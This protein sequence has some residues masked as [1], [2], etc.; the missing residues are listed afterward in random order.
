MRPHTSTYTLCSIREIKLDPD[1]VG[2]FLLLSILTLKLL[3]GNHLPNSQRTED[4]TSPLPARSISL[5]GARRPMRGLDAEVRDGEI[6]VTSF[7]SSYLSGLAGTAPQVGQTCA[8][9]PSSPTSNGQSPPT[10]GSRRSSS[11]CH[12]S[13][14]YGTALCSG[15]IP[16]PLLPD[17]PSSGSL[18]RHVQMPYIG[19]FLRQR[20]ASEVSFR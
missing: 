2:C 7:A 14:L 6:F 5:P 19:V 16:S 1:D 17:T 12:L 13:T 8:E 4:R 10:G 3:G 18:E 9:P 11:T 20:F 15:H